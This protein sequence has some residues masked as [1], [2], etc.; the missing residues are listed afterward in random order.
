MVKYLGVLE[1]KFVI[2]LVSKKLE[3]LRIACIKSS[4]TEFLQILNSKKLEIFEFE[5]RNIQV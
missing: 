1:P 4:E 5:T 2:K 3:K